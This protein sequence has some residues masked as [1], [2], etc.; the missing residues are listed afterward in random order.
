MLAA[1]ITTDL[2]FITIL[3]DTKPNMREQVYDLIKPHVHPSYSPRPFALM[4][5]ESDS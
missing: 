3:R 1:S 2:M 5:F 4:S